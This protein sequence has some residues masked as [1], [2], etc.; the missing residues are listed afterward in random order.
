MCAQ[1]ETARA[2]ER[3]RGT[4]TLDSAE[5]RVLKL[6][7]LFPFENNDSLRNNGME[8]RENDARY[9]KKLL[10]YEDTRARHRQSNTTSTATT[11]NRKKKNDCVHEYTLAC[12]WRSNGPYA[13]SYGDTRY[14]N[15][16]TARIRSQSVNLQSLL[17][18]H[19]HAHYTMRPLSTHSASA[20]KMRWWWSGWNTLQREYLHE[21]R[22]SASAWAMNM[23]RYV[24]ISNT[25]YCLVYVYRVDFNCV[26]EREREESA[27]EI[28]R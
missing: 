25:C 28:E 26:R 20:S 2:N 1:S 18:T 21:E 19:I 5:F 8:N 14:G 24:L 4:I 9:G 11:K 7:P 15:T 22:I 27:I 17:Y 16:L 6:I 13:H 10:L 12:T 3:K 23:C